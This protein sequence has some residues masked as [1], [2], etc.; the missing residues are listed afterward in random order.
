V[1]PQAAG[2]AP[3]RL[4]F[5]G[6]DGDSYPL[7]ESVTVIGRSPDCDL[8]ISDPSISRRHAEI[9]LGAGGASISDLGSTNGTSVNGRPV[10]EQR[11]EPGDR[12]EVGT[13]RLVFE[14]ADS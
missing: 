4:A 2:R 9:R 12:L 7:T 5:I 3:Y 11:I 14:R 1:T 6:S 8:R 13:T 10:R